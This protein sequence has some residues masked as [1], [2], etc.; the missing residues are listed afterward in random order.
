[1]I[2][3]DASMAGKGGTVYG[4]RGLPE[5]RVAGGGRAAVFDAAKLFSPN[6][7]VV[8]SP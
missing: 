5:L 2:E 1:L 7:D 4:Q 3:V 8:A 6:T